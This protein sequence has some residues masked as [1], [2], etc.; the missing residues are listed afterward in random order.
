[1]H[2]ETSAA[3]CYCAAAGLKQRVEHDLEVGGVFLGKKEI[4]DP[5]GIHL[6]RKTGRAAFR[7][8]QHL[9][10]LREASPRRLATNA[11]E[12]YSFNRHSTVR[13][14]SFVL[15]RDTDKALHPQ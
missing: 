6:S 13:V 4:G 5:H 12:I 1:M 8:F 10:E 14:H 9:F 7:R 15:C 11:A 3:L 2:R